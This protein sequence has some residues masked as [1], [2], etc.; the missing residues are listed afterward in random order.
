M[1]DLLKIQSTPHRKVVIF[2]SGGCSDWGKYVRTSQIVLIHLIPYGIRG[3]NAA[4]QL[5]VL[6]NYDSQLRITGGDS[7]R[8]HASTM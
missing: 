5:L 2:C 3:G 1:M 8:L 4:S 7:G 6:R